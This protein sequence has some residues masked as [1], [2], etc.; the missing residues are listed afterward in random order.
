M[1]SDAKKV[2]ILWKK[3]FY[4]SADTD[5]SNKDGMNE[6]TP[7]GLIVFNNRVWVEADKIPTIPPEQSSGVVL[8]HIG[9]SKIK[10]V[11]DKTVVGNRSW[12]LVDQAGKRLIN[13]VPPSLGQDYQARVYLGTINNNISLNP[14]ADTKE[15]VFDYSAGVLTFY[16][17]VPVD[18]LSLNEV[19]EFGLYLEGYQY[20]GKLGTTSDNG[21]TTP[22]SGAINYEIAGSIFGYYT[23]NEIV[24]RFVVA[25]P[26]IFS[27]NFPLSQA[28]CAVPPTEITQ[29]FISKN[30]SVF[31][32]II[33]EPGSTKGIFN[34]LLTT[35]LPG[36][37]LLV[38][39]PHIEDST[40]QHVE[41]T[42]VCGTL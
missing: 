39:A 25:T 27:L 35:L 11:R 16:N 12:Y 15:W 29:F 40:L 13:W 9:V 18:I 42:L 33:F 36:D 5:P 6:T 31:G 38:K 30:G 37:E 20:V 1:L 2:D 41:W 17:C 8:P 3:L 34:G 32:K 4:T 14:L 7:S 26:L 28:R 21:G 10:L 22:S 23:A 19:S 24:M